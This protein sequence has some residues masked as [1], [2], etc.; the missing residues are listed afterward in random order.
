ME[1]VLGRPVLANEA[2]HHIDGDRLNN[3]PFNLMLFATNQMHLHYHFRLNAFNACGHYD[4]SPCCFCH[5]YDNPN[6]LYKNGS[7]HYHR[8]C[9]NEYKRDRYRSKMETKPT[10]EQIVTRI[11]ID[12]AALGNG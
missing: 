1:K 10:A 9:H 4:Y 6:N 2:I 8:E 5:Q 7:H 11:M 12:I 3:S